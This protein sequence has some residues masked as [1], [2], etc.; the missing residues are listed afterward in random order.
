MLRH[1]MYC[2]RTTSLPAS[3]FFFFASL[4]F[5]LST[6]LSCSLVDFPAFF[7]GLHWA[8]GLES[9][10]LYFFVTCSLVFLWV[11]DV[12]PLDWYK[13]IASGMQSKFG[14]GRSLSVP[15]LIIRTTAVFLAPSIV[16]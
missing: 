8:S 10:P 3:L 12:N 11:K 2:Q 6:S 4:C 15:F 7:F 14:K 5:S 1:F 13:T 16:H 9:F